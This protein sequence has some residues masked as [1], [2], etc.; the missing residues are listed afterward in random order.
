MAEVGSGRFVVISM[1]CK[2]ILERCGPR[3]RTEPGGATFSGSVRPVSLQRARIA[4]ASL[5]EPFS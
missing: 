4:A 2:V 1:K 5:E 3:L